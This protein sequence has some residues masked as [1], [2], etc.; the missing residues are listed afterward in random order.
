MSRWVCTK[1]YAQE[2]CRWKGREEGGRAVQGR[3]GGREGGREEGRKGG[4]KRRTAR[5]ENEWRVTLNS[6]LHST[7]RQTHFLKVVISGGSRFL[8]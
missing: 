1:T 8:L 5:Q 7:Q 3:E 4:R 6:G 2:L